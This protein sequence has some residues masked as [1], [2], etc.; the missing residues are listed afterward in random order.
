MKTKNILYL[1]FI[2]SSLLL[3]SCE[4]W[5]D[6]EPLSS[7]TTAS[8]FNTKAQFQA[9]A[10]QLHSDNYGFA[11]CFSSNDAFADHFDC[12][13]DMLASTNEMNAGTNVV[14]TSSV[15]YTNPYNN[16]RK[17]NQLIEAAAAYDGTENI[18]VPLGQ[19]Y[20]FRAWWHF[21]L[22]RKY[23]GVVIADHVPTSTQDPMVVSNPRS[24][25][26]KVMDQIIADIDKSIELL[27]S[28]T[29][30]SSSNDGHVT[31]EAAEAFKGRICLFE[32][33]W[34]KY[35]EKTTD[36]DGVTSG[37]GSDG[38]SATKYTEY[39]TMAKNQAAKFITGGIYANS[40]SIWMPNE[41][42]AGYENSGYY[43][44]FNLEGTGSNPF[45]VNKSS[46]HEA[47]FRSIYDWDSQLRRGN[48]NLSHSMVVSATRKL[49]D[50]YLC[51]DGLPVNKSP[52]FQGYSGLNSEFANRDARATSTMKQIG[53][54]YWGYSTVDGG[55]ANYSTTAAAGAL[56]AGTYIPGLSSYSAVGYSG[57]KF[58]FEQNRADY[59]ES[60]DY[61]HIRL[62]EV[63]L[64]YAEAT[65]EL[66]GSITD[67]ELNNT[68]NKIRLRAHIAN[69]TNA[70]VTNNGLDMLQE[71]RRER[72]IEL[73]GEG[74]RTEDLCRW[75]IAEAELSRPICSY[76]VSYNGSATELATAISPLTSAAIYNAS[77]WSSHIITS[78]QDQ[79]TYLAGVPKVKA[80]SLVIQ[81]KAN[82]NFTK[83][84]YLQYI[85]T[86]QLDLNPNLLQ[87]PSW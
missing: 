13:T 73:I 45:S 64:I 84:N 43:Y 17:V 72:A 37:A 7:I 87:N 42:R 75:G 4:K 38:Y 48:M 18:N 77:V 35:V 57:R 65:L 5:L 85:P 24:S 15:Y 10:N 58:C 74:F 25:R 11:S 69:L 86:A 54:K 67:D 78:D 70:L 83:K 51:T 44:F 8:Y 31:I 82:R 28:F 66:S 33:T 80:G 36:G 23:G 76:Y 6:Q 12:G 21:Y 40:F 62:P 79:S 81:E 32:G 50:M 52:L 41:N 27:N 34:E 53:V 22:L 9:A 3:S 26:Y 56:K 63:Y 49:M 60:A 16:L 39:L 47:I 61:N 14:S 20:F 1:I 71:I 19:A 55:Y 30:S 59:Y 68:I 29:V 2:S 46:N